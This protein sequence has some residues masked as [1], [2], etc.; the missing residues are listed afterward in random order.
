MK[1]TDFEGKTVYIVG[2]SSGIGLSAA[3][4]LAGYGSN[5]F[6][7][8][9][10][11]ERLEDALAK[12][13]NSKKSGVQRSGF[14]QLD[15]TD[16]DQV[17]KVMNEAV[18]EFGAPDILINSQGRAYPN[19][20]EK[21][22]YKQFDETMKVHIYGDWNTVTALLPHMKERGG[23]VV[24]VTS[25]LGFMGAFGY[26]DY[27][28]SKYAIIGFSEVLRSEL[29]RYGIGV[30]ILC[31]PDTDTPGFKVE[32][33]TKPPETVA[34]SEGGGLMQPDE[35]A[36]ALVQGIKK[37]KF[38]IGPGSVRVLWLAKRLVPW[39]VDLYMDHQVKKVRKDSTL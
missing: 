32:N 34:V 24:N 15:V 22:T 25:V 36:A 16:H 20:F 3:T 9:R 23:Y 8:A 30:S 17:N 12:I 1:V 6:I 33:L 29:K 31:P 28:P 2:G 21:I 11:K 10:G 38:F 39:L 37:G 27:C 4:L 19:Y 18:E 14:K 13:D 7:F 35:V 5:V 26:S